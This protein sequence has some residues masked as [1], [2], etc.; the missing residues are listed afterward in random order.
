MPVLFRH[1]DTPP[2]GIDWV[3]AELVRVDDGAVATFRAKGD[4]SRLVVPPSALPVRTD[5]LWQATC[6]ELFVSTGGD[7]YREYN[8]SPSSAWAAYEFDSYREGMRAAAASVIVEFS[9]E[10][11]E[12][13]LAARIKDGLPLPGIVGMTAVIEETDGQLRYWA[14]GFAPGKPDFH[15][16]AV[17]SLLLDGVSA[18]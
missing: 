16:A 7:G 4:L 12:M 1:P 3:E 2:G 8:F 18:Q 6:F 14:T 15:A 13:V 17:R 10:P 11:T 9:R 5:G